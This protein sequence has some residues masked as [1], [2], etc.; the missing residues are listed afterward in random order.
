MDVDDEVVRV[1]RVSIPIPKAEEW[2]RTYTNAARNEVAA[3]PY[4]F[5][6]YDHYDV[7]HN[8]PSRLSD[9]DLLAPVLL[10][11]RMS[12]RAFYG[13]QRIRPE[14]EKA[15][16]HKDLQVPLYG[17]DDPADVAAVVG[18][19]YRVL[20]GSAA[21]SGV[22]GTTLSKVLHRKRPHTLVLHDTWVR[23][24]YVGD[25]ATAPVHKE[26]HRS[27]AEYMSLIS[28]AIGH[29]LRTQ[30]SLFDRLGAATGE[31]GN[32]SDVRLLDILAWMSKGAPPSEA[33]A[34]DE[35]DIDL[36]MS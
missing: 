1:G 25:E 35:A 33:T 30:R 6:A 19:L 15:L 34:S 24:C 7:E 8:E 21:P 11:L 20:D 22:L 12:V 5:P 17:L 14:L 31:P 29:D 16:A 28:V 26:R 2:V 18:P 10:N 36:P 27:W 23:G 32:V 9:A 13:L 4:A 3:N